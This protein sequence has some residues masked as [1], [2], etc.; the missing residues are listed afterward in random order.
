MNISKH[1]K[2]R[3]QQR[4]ISE[5][6]LDIILALGEMNA[7]P[8][9]AM[10]YKILK[11]EKEQAI[12]SLKRLIHKIERISEKSVLASGDNTIITVKI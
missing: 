9:G 4:G 10:E 6:E 5:T 11:R 3:C 8:G 7:K 1:A 12:S 2:I